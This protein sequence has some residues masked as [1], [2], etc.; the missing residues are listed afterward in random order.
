MSIGLTVLGSG[1]R[2]N[3]LLV[4]GA[5]GV[6][7]VDAGFSGRELQRRMKEVSV[8]PEDV[9]AIL[10]SHEHTDH[11][12]GLQTLA[13]RWDVPVFCSRLT[14]DA[15]RGRGI[16]AGRFHLF[17]AG[18]RFAV[19]G[20]EIE[21]FSIPHDAIDPVGFSIRSNGRKVA[22]ATDLGHAS[23]MVQHHLACSDILVLESNHDIAMVRDC[24]R[25]WSVKQ[26]ILSRH[27]HLS[28]EAS[29]AVLRAVLHSATRHVVLGH[30][31]RE[32]NCY[33]LVE[34]SARDCLSTLGRADVNLQ[35]A[36]QDVWSET[37]WC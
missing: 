18:H 6:L 36:R 32:C 22:I 14:G 21:P 9:R 20:F 7:L 16:D 34:R 33:D 27:G 26:R 4:H 8:A 29:A 2:G 3:A 19:E 23:R 37:I 5:S 35:V 24:G 31:S 30:A 1:S 10:V 13:R 25:P 28:N 12:R 11:V 15:I 17:S